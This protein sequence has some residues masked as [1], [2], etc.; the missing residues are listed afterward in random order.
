LGAQGSAFR[1]EVG[2]D[3]SCQELGHQE[4][5]GRQLAAVALAYG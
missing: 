4:A 1:L 5:C 2:K 3:G